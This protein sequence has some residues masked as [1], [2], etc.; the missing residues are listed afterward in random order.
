MTF[1]MLILSSAGGAIQLTWQEAGLF[2]GPQGKC[3]DPELAQLKWAVRRTRN[4]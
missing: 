3:H 4:F 1:P 2:S